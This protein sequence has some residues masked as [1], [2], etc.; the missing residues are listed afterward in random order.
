VL[1]PLSRQQERMDRRLPRQNFPL[2]LPT[3][4]RLCSTVG[5]RIVEGWAAHC[6][7]VSAARSRAAT[8]TN[9]ARSSLA[10]VLHALFGAAKSC[11][12]SIYFWGGLHRHAGPTQPPL[13]TRLMARLAI[14]KHTYDLSDEAL[15]DRWVENPYFQYFFES[16]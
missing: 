13:S 5:G 7:A 12:S 3:N 10:L 9:L 11:R 8:M 2:N 15:C 4:R 14:L 1:G 6:S 16:Y